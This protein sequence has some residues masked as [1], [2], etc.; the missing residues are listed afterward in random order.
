MS[1]QKKNEIEK[2]VVVNDTSINIKLEKLETAQKNLTK[3]KSISKDQLKEKNGVKGIDVDHMKNMTT[4]EK[5]I[6]TATPASASNVNKK[7]DSL[8]SNIDKK[9]S[10]QETGHGRY[11]NIAQE[12]EEQA[13]QKHVSPSRSHEVKNSEKHE[14]NKPV[15]GQQDVLDE[16]NANQLKPPDDKSEENEHIPDNRYPAGNNQ[17]APPDSSN[18]SNGVD[19]NHSNTNSNVKVQRSSLAIGLL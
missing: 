16:N 14:E 3:Q 18:E 2:K 1:L 9:P 5:V 8:S 10:D 15:V 6:I 13:N 19:D 11:G 4:N 7:N 17:L 12:P